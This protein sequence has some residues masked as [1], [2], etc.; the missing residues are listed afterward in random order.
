M[1][2]LNLLSTEYLP[3]GVSEINADISGLANMVKWLFDLFN[4][5]PGAV[6][7]GV[8]VFTLILKTVVLPIETYSKIKTKKQSLLMEKMRPQ[9]EKLQKQYANDKQM[10]SQKVMELQKA[11]GYNPLSACLPTIISLV[12]FIVVFSAFNT[13]ANYATLNNY[14][15]MVKAYNASVSEYILPEGQDWNAAP[16]VYFLKEGEGEYAGNYLVNYDKFTA[17]YTEYNITDDKIGDK[18]KNCDSGTAVA[19]FAESGTFA[20]TLNESEKNEIVAAF[21]R[22]NARQAVLDFYENDPQG[23]ASTKFGWIGN[24]WYPDSMLNKEV[25][26]FTK[27]SSSVSRVAPGIS[28]YAESYNEVTASLGTYKNTYNGYF[29]LIVLAIGLM[30]LQQFIMTRSQKAANE[31]SSVDGSAAKTNKWMMIMM[32]LIYAALSFLY[33][34]TFST[35]MITNTVYGLISTLITNKLVSISFAK[36]ERDKEL[37]RGKSVPK[38]K[39]LK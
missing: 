12:I 27:F 18:M 32:P 20:D 7:V 30:F 35:Y 38:R 33:T 24:V 16:N 36:K 11:N 21:V 3:F 15:N 9:M 14:N 13:Y 31:L 8:I 4:G 29:V 6:I 10:Y 26:D 39:R 5:F 1:D 2:I 23:R 28:T 37:N 19:A 34:A 17:Y 25:P 22:C